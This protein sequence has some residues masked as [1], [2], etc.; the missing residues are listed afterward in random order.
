VLPADVNLTVSGFAEAG[1]THGEPQPRHRLNGSCLQGAEWA[2]DVRKQT[3]TQAVLF[4]YK[5]YSPKNN[6]V[7]QF[8][9][10]IRPLAVFEC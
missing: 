6:K 8:G 2:F 9:S 5:V 10:F 4:F 7:S 3:K 1:F